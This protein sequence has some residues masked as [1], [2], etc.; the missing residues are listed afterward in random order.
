MNAT[1]EAFVL[2]G[3]FLTVGLLGG[4][5]IAD[6]VH[7]TPPPLAALVLGVLLVANLSRASVLSPDRLMNINR[8]PLENVSGGVVL[9]SLFWASTQVFNLV[10]PDRGLLHALFSTFFVVQLLTTLAGSTDRRSLLRSLLV[11]L[12]SAFVLRFIVLEGLYAPESGLTRRIVTAL[13]EGVSLGTLDYAPNAA[14]TGYVAF[15]TLG[16]YMVGLTLLPSPAGTDAVIR[17]VHRIED[18]TQER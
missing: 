10:T 9:A 15:L 16:L 13:L 3:I 1:R 5:R 8:S 17:A 2:P 6:A 11:L 12:G 4:L 14:S 18:P 7:L